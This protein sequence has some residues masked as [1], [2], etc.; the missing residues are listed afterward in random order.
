[1]DY[2][3]FG[4]MDKYD[5]LFAKWVGSGQHFAFINQPE[6]AV[7]NYFTLFQS[8]TPVLGKDP[9]EAQQLFEQGAKKILEEAA[10]VWRQKLG[11]ATKGHPAATAL[12][13]ELEPMMRDYVDFTIF[14]RQL[15]AVADLPATE[16][17]LFGPLAKAFY[18]DPSDRK[19]WVDWLVKWR[20]AL[21]DEEG[22]GSFT[23]AAARLR[24]ANPKYVPREWILAQCYTE[25]S[26]GNYSM[27]HDLYRLFLEP[28][29]E[30]P[31]F[32]DRYY[33]LA[34]TQDLRKG[35]VAKMT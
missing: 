10:D 28:Y 17:E 1:M 2:G 33:R 30:H 3:P 6:A 26:T 24:A 16:T 32:E 14:W 18:I 23:D 20:K 31:E 5:P 4:W 8:V 7:A 13:E 11:F 9:K 27:L 15:A 19:K 21:A 35:G 29:S 25:A 34:S 12:W 22:G